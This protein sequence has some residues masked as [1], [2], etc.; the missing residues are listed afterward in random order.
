MGTQFE[1]RLLLKSEYQSAVRGLERVEAGDAHALKAIQDRCRGLAER[2]S[3]KKWHTAMG[4]L[5]R[6]WVK[7]I[8]SFPTHASKEVAREISEMFIALAAMPDYQ[9]S[10]YDSDE[11]SPNLVVIG[12]DDGGLYA[13]LA[14][15]DS[16]FDRLF[17][18][19]YP[20]S[21]A[22]FGVGRAMIVLDREDTARFNKVVKSISREQCDQARSPEACWKTRGRLLRL[23]E[24]CLEL[25]DGQI[26][27][28]ESG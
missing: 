14:D 17:F 25:E 23:L 10:Y 16:W 7:K 8:N 12:E 19:R 15:A 2:D 26:A 28:S 27:V 6:Q 21:S 13:V 18:E 20:Q 11:L 22:R 9:M 3:F 1:C 4:Y 24:K 5:Y